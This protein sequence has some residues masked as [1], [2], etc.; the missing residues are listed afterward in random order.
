M[1][2]ELVPRDKKTDNRITVQIGPGVQK[3]KIRDHEVFAN[4]LAQVITWNLD[5]GL[6]RGDFVS[7]AWT[8]QPPAAGIFGNPEI[9]AD[10][11]SLTLRNLNN[12]PTKTQGSFGYIITIELDDETYT[13]GE[14]ISTSGVMRDPIIINK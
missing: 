11:N 1:D 2:M 13:S 8:G 4:P 7:F 9:S 5:P 3:L 10:G 6:K 14:T 12:D